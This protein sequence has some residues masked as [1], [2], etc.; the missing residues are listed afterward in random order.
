M[1]AEADI[2]GIFEDQP[3]L[4][5]HNGF[6]QMTL[7]G[8]VVCETCKTPVDLSDDTEKETN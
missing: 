4:C 5:P 2:T 3:W 8:A 1:T 6:L 7:D